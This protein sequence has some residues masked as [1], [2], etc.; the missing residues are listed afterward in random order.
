MLRVIKLI[1]RACES[2]NKRMQL[3]I[4]LHS[5]RPKYRG[6]K[7]PMGLISLQADPTFNEIHQA[8]GL[9]ETSEELHTILDNM[10]LVSGEIPR[11]TSYE[12]G[13][14]R[15]MRFDDLHGW[16]EDELIR[17]E[18][19]LMCKLKGHIAMRFEYEHR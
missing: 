7:T 19:F 9:V 3:I 10:F 1:K 18:R 11:Q 5:D 15:G 12:L 8:G 16:T 14:R 17:D 6:F 13:L 2:A 4:D